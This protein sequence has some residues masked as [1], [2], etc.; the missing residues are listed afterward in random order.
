[1]THTST[2]SLVATRGSVRIAKVAQRRVCEITK[3]GRE[4]S[5]VRSALRCDLIKRLRNGGG[6]DGDGDGFG[7]GDGGFGDGGG[8]DGFGDGDGDGGGDG[9]VDGG[10]GGVAGGGGED[11]PAT[12]TLVPNVCRNIAWADTVVSKLSCSDIAYGTDCICY[13]YRES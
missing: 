4:G 3:G 6:G 13:L 10:F 12:M 7:G 1:M 5:Q 2:C 8:G 11:G 9:F